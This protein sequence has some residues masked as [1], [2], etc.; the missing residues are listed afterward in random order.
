MG[1]VISAS[2]GSTVYSKLLVTLD[3]SPLAESAIHYTVEL[4]NT[5]G[6]EEVMLL[7]FVEPWGALGIQEA[8]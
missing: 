4:A 5:A 6:S 7:R 3:G 8:D 2:R 1:A